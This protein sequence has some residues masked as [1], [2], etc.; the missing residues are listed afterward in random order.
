MR[1]NPAWSSFCRLVAMQHR[2]EVPL[3]GPL[4]AEL[5]F[6]TRRP[7]RP[8]HPYPS[9]SDVENLAKGLLDAF[10][11]VLYDNDS[12]L[13]DVVLRKRWTLATEGVRVEVQT[14]S[15]QWSPEYKEI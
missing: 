15:E 13:V 3:A 9:R 10:Q 1:L 4:A 2:P 6:L 14:M 12:Q 7:K 11:G 8:G 5:L